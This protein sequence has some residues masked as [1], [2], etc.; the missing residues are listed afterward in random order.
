MRSNN[1]CTRV[2]YVC[3]ANGC[4]FSLKGAQGRREQAPQKCTTL[5]ISSIHRC[6]INSCLR[7]LQYSLLSGCPQYF[8]NNIQKVQNNAAWLVLRVLKTADHISHLASLHWLPSDSRIQRKLASL[9]Y[10]CLSSTAPVNFT[11]LLKVYKPTPSYALLLFFV[12]PLC[13]R[14][15]SV[16]DLCLM[17]H[18]LSGTVSLTKSDRHTH[19]YL[20]NHL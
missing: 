1:T 5:I 19:S 14:T 4:C 16:R 12:S 17:L 10:N 15:R 13:A 9:C 20:S 3:F 7:L 6:H 2:G 18:R 8:L 11:E